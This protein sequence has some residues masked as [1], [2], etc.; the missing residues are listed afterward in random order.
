[1]SPL[2]SVEL[3]PEAHEH[4]DEVEVVVPASWTRSEPV[5][6]DRM[7]FADEVGHEQSVELPAPAR[8]APFIEGYGSLTLFRVPVAQV[9]PEPART[10]ETPARVTRHLGHRGAMGAA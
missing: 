7:V 8:T 3:V 4:D 2:S 10:P 6:G 5:A 9:Q 1:M